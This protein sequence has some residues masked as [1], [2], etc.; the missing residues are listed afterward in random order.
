[1][2]MNMIY[3]KQN[4]DAKFIIYPWDLDA[5]WG[6]DWDSTFLFSQ[7]WLSNRCYSR[8]F[9][10]N[11]GGSVD[12]MK[13]RWNELRS[14]LFTHTS[15]IE[16]FSETSNILIESGAYKREK[17]CWPE[18][19]LNLTQEIAYIDDWLEKR[20]IYLDCKMQDAYT[21]K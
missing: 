1:M 19:N 20:I 15:L 17:Y 5:S 3:A 14:D 12:R 8:L 9:N 2:G 11:V 10:E 13:S 16:R 4:R 18:M 6:R 21:D 7:C